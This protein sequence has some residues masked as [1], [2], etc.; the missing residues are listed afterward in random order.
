[1]KVE[2]VQ[3]ELLSL[4]V[5]RQDGNIDLHTLG[6]LRWV[7]QRHYVGIILE[8]ETATTSTLFMMLEGGPSDLDILTLP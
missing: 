5:L 1:M 6:K 7:G 4:E 3:L 8:A 2:G